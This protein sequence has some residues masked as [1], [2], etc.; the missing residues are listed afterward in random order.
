MRS[1]RTA[2]LYSR[3]AGYIGR[4]FRKRRVYL[5]RRCLNLDRA[6]ILLSGNIRLGGTGNCGARFLRN[7]EYR[8][9]RD[10]GQ[11]R[12]ADIHTPQLCSDASYGGRRT[13]ARH[14]HCGHYSLG[15]FD[16]FP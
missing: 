5:G 3:R 8:H 4:L 1:D 2:E 11:H 13:G 7:A 14:V 9:T 16:R 12:N 6:H 15:R 10:S